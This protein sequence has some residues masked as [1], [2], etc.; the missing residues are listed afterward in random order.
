M[1]ALFITAA[2]GAKAGTLLP[3]AW[4]RMGEND[5]GA[6]DGGSTYTAKNEL[7]GGLMLPQGARFSADVPNN[8]LGST[9]GLRLNTGQFGINPVVTDA[10]DNF[11]LELWVKPDSAD[12]PQ[13]LAYNGD[14]S[15]TGWGIYLANGLYVG[16]IGGVAFVGGSPAAQGVWTH[17]AL[18]RDG[19]VATLYVN[20]VS[21]GADASE[22]GSPSGAFG[23]GVAPQTSNTEFLAGGT[24]D[25]VRVFVFAAGEF[26]PSDL[27]YNYGRPKP[28]SMTLVPVGRGGF[29]FTNATAISFSVLMTT[30][31]ALPMSAWQNIGS[32]TELPAGTGHYQFTDPQTANSPRRY[33][34][35]TFP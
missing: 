16:V 14:S 4:W 23:V 3:V 2:P 31:L 21:A 28:A 19:G 27:L 24:I 26:N 20:G 5:P 32:A 9:L 33:Y 18:V 1:A 25:E 15:S 8:T 10:I 30:N 7:G 34:R 6:A 12:A 11:G 35:V 22:P 29:T 13:C 17:V